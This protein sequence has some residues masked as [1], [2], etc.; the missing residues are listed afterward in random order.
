MQD[1]ALQMR[2]GMMGINNLRRKNGGSLLLVI[3]PDKPVLL[4]TEFCNREIVN[5]G[6]A[7]FLLNGEVD[8][9]AFF[10]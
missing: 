3:L 1:F 8:G 2:E 6:S 7:K 4:D 5:T 9:I 10:D